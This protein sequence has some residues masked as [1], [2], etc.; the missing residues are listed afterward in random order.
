MKNYNP[1]CRGR[2]YRFF[3]ESDGSTISITDSDL[4]VN[5]SSQYIQMPKGFH[6]IDTKYDIHTVEGSS[7]ANMSYVLRTYNDG[8]QGIIMPGKDA[9]DYGYVYAF[10]YFN[11]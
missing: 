11:D 5:H 7:A 3:I 1:F 6:V 8:S 2:W 10:G 9:F 4:E